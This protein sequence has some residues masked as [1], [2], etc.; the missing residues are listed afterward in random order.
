MKLAVVGVV[1]AST[2]VVSVTGT[3]VAQD[4]DDGRSVPVSTSI[5]ALMVALVDHSAHEI[6]EAGSADNLAGLDWDIAEQNAIQLI[7]SGTLVSLGG[8]GIA[9]EGWAAAPEWQEWSRAMTDGALAAR[10]AIQAFDQDALSDAGDTILNACQGC[11]QVFKPELPTEGLYH[12]PHF[13]FT[14]QQ[15]VTLKSAVVALTEEPELRASFEESL[16]ARAVARNYNAVTSYQLIPDV[17]DVDDADFVRRMVSNGIGAVLLVRPAAVGP[18]ATLESVRNEVSPGVYANMR[19]FA[20]QLSPSG[21]EDLLEV[22][23]LGLYLISVQGAELVSSGAVWLSE[24]YPTQEER[25]ERLQ[26]L[27]V[28]NVDNVRPAIRQHLGLPP[29]E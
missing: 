12:I 27:I 15:T 22:V 29:L 25:V 18:G 23:H 10:A 16:V 21:E 17:S 3:S 2:L 8:T 6:W 24:P 11:H 4:S 5:N 20:R 28:A 19:S 7:A 13:D 1:A 14:S 9:D 26:N